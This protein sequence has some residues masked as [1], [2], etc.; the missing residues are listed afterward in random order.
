[1]VLRLGEYQCQQCGTTA[2][3]VAP[4]EKA[5]TSSQGYGARGSGYGDIAGGRQSSSRLPA[6]LPPP[7]QAQ[8]D[9]GAQYRSAPPPPAYAT[10]GGAG[11]FAPD[12]AVGSGST[13]DLE[14]KIYFG[15]HCLWTLVIAGLGSLTLGQVDLGMGVSPGVRDWIGPTIWISALLGLA[16][17][18]WV[19]FGTELWSK[20][21][22]L[23]CT[24]LGLLGTLGSIFST[25]SATQLRIFPQ[26]QGFSDHAL[27]SYQIVTGLL[28]LMWTGWFLSI[29]AR[30]AMRKQQGY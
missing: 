5:P 14:K 24:G 27:Q 8:Y 20:W 17:L 12:S 15:L 21:A 16:I 4:E 2:P 10:A 9:P 23:G 6:A 19:L 26:L 3:L 28:Q 1:M 11:A 7:A 30:D 13:L 29:L 18:F 25:A 22:C